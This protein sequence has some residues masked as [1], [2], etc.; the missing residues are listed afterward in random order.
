MMLKCS[1][2]GS[3]FEVHAHDNRDGEIQRI[4]F[5]K[6]NSSKHGGTFVTSGVNYNGSDWCGRCFENEKENLKNAGGAPWL[7]V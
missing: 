3:N 6:A 2:C 1:V 4:Y 5:S 7:A